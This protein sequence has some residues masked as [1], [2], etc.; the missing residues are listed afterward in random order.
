MCCRDFCPDTSRFLAFLC[1][2][3][4]QFHKAAS[5][6]INYSGGLLEIVLCSTR[7]H[8]EATTTTACRSQCF[9]TGPSISSKGDGQDK[10][11]KHAAAYST[12]AIMS[13]AN[14]AA[15]LNG[16]QLSAIIVIAKAVGLAADIHASTHPCSHTSMH[17]GFHAPV[18]PRIQVT[19]MHPCIFVQRDC[20]AVHLRHLHG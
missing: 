2:K 9:Q 4:L 3:S 13:L 16:L 6:P 14:T 18:R 5:I 19:T 7:A 11:T 1:K 8:A 15:I 10:P 12:K 20:P 17:P